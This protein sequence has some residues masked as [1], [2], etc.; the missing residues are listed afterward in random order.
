MDWILSKQKDFIGRRSLA[1]SDCLRA[2]RKQLVGLLTEQ[3]EQILPEGAQ[4][5]D[6]A[7]VAK[8]VPMIGHVTSSYFSDCLQRSIALAVVKGGRQ[9]TGDTVQAPLADGSVV[10]ATIVSP[11]FYDPDGERQHA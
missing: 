7:D 10:E 9:R 1:R 3:P 11:V 2:G 4:L 6:D 5:V 8:P